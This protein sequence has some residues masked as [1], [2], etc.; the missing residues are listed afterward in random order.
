MSTQSPSQRS[1][2]S[3]AEQAARA[4][5]RAH[6]EHVHIFAVPGRPGV[7]TTKSKSDP[8]ERH[9]LVVDGELVACSCKGFEYRRCCKH[10]QALINRLAR[11]AV[12][13][14]RQVAARPRAQ[15]SDL[16]GPEF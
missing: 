11:E 1:P 5:A 16:Y 10:S 6:S 14:Q 4:T 15:V 12:A 7:Y 3:Q 2:M 13:A 9:S 8:S